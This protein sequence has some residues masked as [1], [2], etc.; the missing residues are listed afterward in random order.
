MHVHQPA[1]YFDVLCVSVHVLGNTLITILFDQATSAYRCPLA[2]RCTHVYIN[3]IF[4]SFCIEIIVI[5]ND[6]SSFY[7]I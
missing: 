2:M 7:K 6:I 1:N 5:M 3:I 4:I